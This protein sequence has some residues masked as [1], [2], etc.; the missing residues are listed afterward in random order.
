MG[1]QRFV[2]VGDSC[3]EGLDDPYP[4]HSQYRGWADFVAGRLARHEPGFRYANLAVRGRRLDRITA[5][6]LPTA[7]RLEPD[8]IA[9]FGGGN[10]VMS[11]GWDART[12]ARRVDAAIRHCTRIAPTVVT[13]TLSDISHRMPLGTRMRPRVTALNDAIREASVSYGAKLV[14][15]WPDQAAHD[16]RYFGPDRLHL[17]ETGHLRVAGHVLNRLGIGHDGDWL[18]PLPG[19]PARSSVREDLLWLCKEVLPVGV[20]RLRNR[21]IGRSPGDGFLP[22]RPDLL[23]VA[24][25]EAQL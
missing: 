20:T 17:S 18:R 25:S 2:A 8:L 10:D 6:Q 15:L 14:D 22:K 7:E 3:A 11:R 5:E 9:L 23:P 16:A 1:F 21:L 4:D 13:F 24:F 12:V 19:V